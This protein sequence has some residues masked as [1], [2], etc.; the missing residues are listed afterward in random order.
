MFV[1]PPANSPA[2]VLKGHTEAVYG[3]AI[4]ADGKYVASAG[5]DNQLLLWD[6][7]AA[8][9]IAELKGHTGPPQCVSFHP[10]GKLLASGGIRQ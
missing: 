2:G 3:V 6:F 5:N 4:S 9:K 1:T 7:A 10:D 8:K